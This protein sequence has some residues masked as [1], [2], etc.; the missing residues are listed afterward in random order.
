MEK[1]VVRVWFCNRRQKEKRI[2]CPMPSPIKSPIYNSRLVRDF[3]L[4]SSTCRPRQAGKR[5]G[6]C[7]RVCWKRKH[8]KTFPC[9]HKSLSCW[10]AHSTVWWGTTP[11]G[12]CREAAGL[13]TDW[14][15][16]QHPNLN[17]ISCLHLQN[18]YFYSIN[19]NNISFLE[20]TGQFNCR[21]IY[22]NRGAIPKLF[23]L[24]LVNKSFPK[25]MEEESAFHR[26]RITS[27]HVSL[28]VNSE[29]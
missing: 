2:S 13:A 11:A 10:Q 29:T 20:G 4:R 16:T 22:P 25:L 19:E 14:I 7:S 17:G 23:T 8:D 6:G 3:G 9:T 12:V 28:V 24:R 1:E 21:I 15:Y 27:T 26:I 5:V 18:I